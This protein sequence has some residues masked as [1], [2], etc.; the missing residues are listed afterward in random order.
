MVYVKGLFE[1]LM[2]YWDE[3]ENASRYFVH[4]MIGNATGPDVSYKEIKLVEC[5]R[6]T[7]FYSFY[8]LAMIDKTAYNGMYASGDTGLNYFVYVE[9]EDKDGKIISTS[10]KQIGHVLMFRDGNYL[11]KN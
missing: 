7:K 8:G 5:D 10:S 9:A 1:G 3:V 4:L 6:H 2:V 11:H